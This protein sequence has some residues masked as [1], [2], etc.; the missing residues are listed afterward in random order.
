MWERTFAQEE[1]IG[2]KSLALPSFL[3]N[4]CRPVMGTDSV[5]SFGKV[6][7]KSE[8]KMEKI[9]RIIRGAF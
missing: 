7:E 4:I 5:L 6:G 8:E 3:A 1:F 2:V 9:W